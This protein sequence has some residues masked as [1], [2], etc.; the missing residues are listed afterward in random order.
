MSKSRLRVETVFRHLVH[1]L[2]GPSRDRPLLA[3]EREFIDRVHRITEE[4]L[5][6]ALFT[7]ADAAACLDMS[8]M[9]LNRRLRRLTGQSTHQLIREMR[10]QSARQILVRES[11]PVA[12]VAERVGFKSL[13]Q[14]TAA[15]RL[16]YGVPPGEYRKRNPEVSPRGHS[17]R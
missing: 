12:A 5:A 10:L 7:T 1:G 11:S 9:H 4:H 14:F 8:R 16:K 2:T 6:D 17:P 15:F 13:S 3:E